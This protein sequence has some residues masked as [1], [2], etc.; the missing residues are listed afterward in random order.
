[1]GERG[2][3]HPV[4][5]RFLDDGLEARYQLEEGA[6][7]RTGVLIAALAAAI[8][9]PVAA[10]ILPS[11]TGLSTQVAWTAA[12][13]GSV[14]ALACAWFGRSADTVNR[15]HIALVSLTAGSGLVIIAISVAVDAFHG[16]AVAA[17]MLL[18]LFSFV[19]GTRFV[20]AAVRSLAIAIGFT[21]AAIISESEASLALDVFLFVTA[22]IASSLGLRRSEREQRRV[23][24]QRL[25]IAEQADEA[26]R[27]LL[28]I[29][30]AAIS[31]RLRK[32]ESPI[33][34]AYPAV[35]VLNADLKGF[36]PY[37]V[38]Q[39]EEVV[40]RF[41]SELFLCFDNLVEELGLEKIKLTGDGY[42]AAG[43]LPD[44]I[45]DHATRVV[46]LGIAMIEA[47]RDL[48]EA[49]GLELRVGI[50]SGAVSGGVIGNR[51]FAYDLWGN[52]VN[53][54][55]RLQSSCVPGRVHVSEA[56]YRLTNDRFAYE[57]R[58]PIELAGIGV[59]STFLVAAEEHASR[60]D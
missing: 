45:D 11:A 18:H 26:D 42:V 17:V 12:G 1:M 32:G 23:Y 44:P 31:V 35:S 29:L 60:R 24:H 38:Q 39:P 9:W 52:T 51:R 6:K 48:R 22:T 50:D 54:A 10:L 30:P 4:T 2:D 58:D 59:V 40:I 49:A 3:V 34:D 53:L 5:L 7:G 15:Q 36:T 25:V 47:S 20:I 33:A 56:T 28:N 27:L 43:G 57:S 41:L 46:E 37:S 21:V 19:S 55:E 13:A 14:A 8:L 16:Y